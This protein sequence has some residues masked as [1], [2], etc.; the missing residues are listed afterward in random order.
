MYKPDWMAVLQN[1]NI[2]K[3][4]KLWIKAEQYG[5]PFMSELEMLLA[6]KAC[7]GSCWGFNMRTENC[8]IPTGTSD[9]QVTCQGKY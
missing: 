8:F 7:A 2:D 4:M 1:L 3:A 5:E 9:I 6:K